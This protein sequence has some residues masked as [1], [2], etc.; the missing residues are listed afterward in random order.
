MEPFSF[1]SGGSNGI[2]WATTLYRLGK[3]FKISRN[4]TVGKES[5]KRKETY[6]VLE[7]IIDVSFQ[8][9]PSCQ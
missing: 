3:W 2:P 7:W 1:S 4:R 6:H 8:Y 9:N 5:L